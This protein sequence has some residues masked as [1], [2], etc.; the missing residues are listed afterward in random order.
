MDDPIFVFA[1]SYGDIASAE[2]DYEVIK[3]LHS[4]DEI[5]SYDAAVISRGRDGM[6]TVHKSE[7][8]TPRDP[9]TG[10]A[11]GAASAVLCPGLARSDAERP[12][13][14]AWVARIAEG[15]SRGQAEEMGA[16]VEEDR[17]ALVVVGT[18]TDA[19]R[20]EQTAVE[21]N[22]TTLNYTGR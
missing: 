12:E 14:D 15:L 6:L 16:L 2:G 10:V 7:K 17:A 21:A 8:P 22:R 13:L 3:L 11:A 19:G 4:C 20:I 1:G 9:W 18:E 5:G